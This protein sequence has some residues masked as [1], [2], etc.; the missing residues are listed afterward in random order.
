MVDCNF[1][2]LK[3]QSNFRDPII[4]ISCTLIRPL[5]ISLHVPQE[6]LYNKNNYITFV[7][8]WPMIK[9]KVMALPPISQQWR[10]N[11]SVHP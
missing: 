1:Q 6:K 3:L 10:T 7:Y 5:T 9:G 2:P 4:T 11:R 8:K